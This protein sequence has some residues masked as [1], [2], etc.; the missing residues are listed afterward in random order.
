MIVTFLFNLFFVLFLVWGFMPRY[1]LLSCHKNEREYLI[2]RVWRSFKFLPWA[3]KVQEF[4]GLKHGLWYKDNGDTV[5]LWLSTKLDTL[6]NLDETIGS[7]NA[8]TTH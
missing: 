5:G 3:G 2:L 7:G 1:R 6:V 8:T 4:K